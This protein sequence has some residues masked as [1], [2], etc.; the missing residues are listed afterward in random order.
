MLAYATH[1]PAMTKEELLALE[2]RAKAADVSIAQIC[3]RADINP[4]NWAKWKKHG[5]K[6]RRVIW[7]R[8]QRAANELIAE[9]DRSA[10]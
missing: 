5:T 7:E 4:G 1:M 9:R 2:A 8:A 10:A 6:P 3:R